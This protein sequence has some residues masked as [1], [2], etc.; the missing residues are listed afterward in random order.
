MFREF[1]Q[2]DVMMYKPFDLDELVATIEKL[3]KGGH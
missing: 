1:S 2:A 3:L